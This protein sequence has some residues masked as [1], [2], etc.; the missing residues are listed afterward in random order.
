MRLSGT[1]AA[2]FPLYTPSKDIF[3]KDELSLNAKGGTELMKA[4]LLRNVDNELLSNFQIFCSRVRDEEIDPDRIKLLWLH[5]LWND[6]ETIHLKNKE[7]RDR[8]EKL[9]F[10]SHDQFKG[11]NLGLGVPYGK[12]LIL[13]NAIEPISVTSG[14]KPD[15]NEQIRLIYS[16]TPHRGLELLIPVFIKLYENFGDAVHLDVYSS[17]QVYG[18]P[19]RDEQYK[20]L[21]DICKEHPGI[22]YH[23]AVSNDEVRKAL[24]QSHIYAYPC[25]WPET[26]CISVIEAMSAKCMVVHPN[27]GALPETTHD[28]SVMYQFTEDR[29]EHINVFANTLMRAIH[30]ARDPDHNRMLDYVKNNIDNLYSWETRGKQWTSLL[31]Q[32]LAK[33]NR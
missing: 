11:Y 33:G 23:G 19:Q 30:M 17:F 29:R 13:K 4:G 28:L 6:P 3:P 31:Q 12:S 18:W 9:I 8:F 20:P 5:D 2:Y 16:T 22:T 21:F 25:I 14:D 15:P 32:L 27:Y 24:A 7:S 26:S 10:V 1:E